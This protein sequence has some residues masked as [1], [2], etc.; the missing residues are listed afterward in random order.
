[1]SNNDPVKSGAATPGADGLPLEPDSVSE[2]LFAT[3][4][5][6]VEIISLTATP[7]AVEADDLQ[8][9]RL[10][11]VL[12]LL[13]LHKGKLNL[14]PSQ[15]FPLEVEQRR[16]SEFF[17]HDFHGL[18]SHVTP[19]PEV[20]VR[21]VVISR[22]ATDS[23][24]ALMQEGACVRLLVPAYESDI[25]LALEAERLYREIF[26]AANYESNNETEYEPKHEP[27]TIAAARALLNFTRE[28]VAGC[29]D[30]YA[31]YFWA[32]IQPA[33][34]A[35]TELLLPGVLTL[36]SSS[37]AKNSFRQTT[38]ALIYDAALD[39]E[40]DSP[41]YR[42]VLATF[43]AL[44]LQPEASLLHEMLVEVQ[45]YNLIFQD[46][47]PRFNSGAMIPDADAHRAVLAALAP[48]KTERAQRIKVWLS[49]GGS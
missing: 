36:A 3:H 20:G 43:V 30:I 22:A 2:L 28:R 23:P 35:N 11:I 4:L 10:G 32:R 15:T 46:Q 7:W 12:R 47:R 5:F 27:P 48:F 41:P 1:M 17:N 16:E 37:N 34:L 42:I 14:Q 31:L 44:L 25:L 24:A 6:T 45:L 33:L 19:Q 9:R 39:F 8:H 40:P 26:A 49:A 13:A 18:W 21:Y 38:V 29:R